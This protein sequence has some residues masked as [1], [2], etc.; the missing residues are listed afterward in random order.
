MRLKAAEQEEIFAAD[1]DHIYD[2]VSLTK[3]GVL[4]RFMFIAD[5][6]T[7]LEQGI[8]I[9]DVEGYSSKPVFKSEFGKS[10]DSLEV[11]AAQDTV[12]VQGNFDFKNSYKI[13]DIKA[14]ITSLIDNNDIRDLKA[15]IG[16]T[17]DYVEAI[18]E[19]SETVGID[20]VI[21]GSPPYVKPLISLRSATL[22]LLGNCLDPASFVGKFPVRSAQAAIAIESPQEEIRKLSDFTLTKDYETFMRATTKSISS[23]S[24]YRRVTATSRFVPVKFE[25]LIPVTEIEKEDVLYLVIR[26]NHSNGKMFSR[27]VFQA[28]SL[29]ELITTPSAISIGSYLKMVNTIARSLQTFNSRQSPQSLRGLVRN[30]RGEP[31]NDTYYTELDLDIHNSDIPGVKIVRRVGNDSFYGG[32]AF[33]TRVYK[34]KSNDVSIALRNGS[35]QDSEDVKF[36]ITRKE[37]SVLIKVTKLA[38]D[39]AESIVLR[40]DITRNE[41]SFSH[42]STDASKSRSTDRSPQYTDSTCEDGHNYEYAIGLIDKFGSLE[43]SDTKHRYTFIRKQEGVKLRIANVASKIEKNGGNTARIVSFSIVPS[44]VGKKSNSQYQVM[45][46]NAIPTSSIS[47]FIESPDTHDPIFYFEIT[48]ENIDTGD[49]ELCGVFTTTEFVDDSAKIES[50]LPLTPLKTDGSYKYNVRLGVESAAALIT[51]QYAIA[52]SRDGKKYPFHSYKFRK[53]D[54]LA[55]STPSDREIQGSYKPLFNLIDT[56]V[57]ASVKVT[58]TKRT[59]SISSVDVIRNRGGFN[60]IKWRVEGNEDVIDHY[61][62][63]ASADGIECLLGCVLR[64]PGENVFFDSEMFDR[65]GLVT[66]RVAPVLLDF[67]E[68]TSVTESIFTLRNE[69]D[70]IVERSE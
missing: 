14:D 69:P 34:N 28:P 41:E 57:E 49:V 24:R 38:S 55:N 21:V 63:Y 47:D 29:R 1:P 67:S 65:V 4:V 8:T 61:R 54:R 26:A 6:V 19:G 32:F 58:G 51:N 15:G 45:K 20:E 22:G 52:V 11:A 3:D 7:L 35:K 62:V 59:V 39:V 2:S 18:E 31:T 9:V 42:L 37:D 43:V 60:V 25:N 23:N 68:T 48:R 33:S 50:T 27:F 5:A 30:F 36:H 17:F 12:N 66:Y 56:G 64:A 40:R 70:F 10:V 46:N 53:T 16:R 13:F 44:Q